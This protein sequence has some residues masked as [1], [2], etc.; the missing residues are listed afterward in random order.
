MEVWNGERL[1]CIMVTCLYT[2]DL[3]YIQM[4]SE[5][6]TSCPHVYTYPPL[7]SNMGGT[8]DA[9]FFYITPA[10]EIFKSVLL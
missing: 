2:P 5:V 6:M 4:F 8:F 1:L 9:E 7:Y 3:R 10:D